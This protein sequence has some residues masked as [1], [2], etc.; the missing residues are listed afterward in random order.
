[1][2]RIPAVILMIPVIGYG[3][4]SFDEAQKRMEARQRERV[5]RHSSTTTQPAEMVNQPTTRPA[6]RAVQPATKS[7]TPSTLDELHEA[8]VTHQQDERQAEAEALARL[9]AT[10]KFISA[11]ADLDR[12]KAKLDKA[13]ASGTSEQRIQASHDFLATKQVLE[14]MEKDAINSSPDVIASSTAASQA[15]HA[16]YTA[17]REAEAP[18]VSGI[19]QGRIVLGMTEKQALQAFRNRKQRNAIQGTG[20]GTVGVDMSAQ[21]AIGIAAAGRLDVLSD[22][23]KTSRDELG[24]GVQ[25]LSLMKYRH[26]MN[27]ED[28]LV[29][30]VKITLTNGKVSQIFSQ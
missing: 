2:K 8:M 3:Q 4:M 16:Y 20:G 25:R 27:G 22:V 28:V 29:D 12:A 30:E 10:P 19:E 13:R 23:I 6:A 24:D 26:H 1:M 18:I 17:Q 11:K 15:N 5:A 9:H 14:T 21:Q 7:A